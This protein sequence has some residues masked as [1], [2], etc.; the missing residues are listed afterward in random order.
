MVGKIIFFESDDFPADCDVIDEFDVALPGISFSENTTRFLPTL[1]STADVW[2][3]RRRFL[4]TFRLKWKFQKYF[5]TIFNENSILLIYQI[6]CF[7]RNTKNNQQ[8]NK[9]RELQ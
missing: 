5:L 8:L 3:R 9:C 2:L 6:G 4:S 1:D 7:N